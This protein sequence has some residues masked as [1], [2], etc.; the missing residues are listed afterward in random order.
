MWNAFENFP[1]VLFDVTGQSF[2]IRIISYSLSERWRLHVHHEQSSTTCKNVRFLT[3]VLWKHCQLSHLPT[4]FG[5]IDVFLFDALLIFYFLFS[6]VKRNFV[7]PYLRRV[8]NFRA[9]IVL[10]L[11]DRIELL[12]EQASAINLF[13]SLGKTE[14]CNYQ[15]TLFVD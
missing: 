11:Y 13:Q 1:E 9:N 15:S 14:I 3:V 6:F 2:V 4:Y 10:E 12:L 8:V 7:V 5:V